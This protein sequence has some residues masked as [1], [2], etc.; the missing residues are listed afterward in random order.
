MKLQNLFSWTGGAA[1]RRER[2]RKLAAAGDRARDRGEWA[3]AARQY[4][5]ALTLDPDRA[6]IWV[7]YGHALKEQG[8]LAGAEAAYKKSI[9]IDEATADAHLQLGHVLKLQGRKTDAIS[10]YLDALIRDPEFSEP[11]RELAALDYPLTDFQAVLADLADAA[12]PNLVQLGLRADSAERQ[13]AVLLNRSEARARAQFPDFCVVDVSLASAVGWAFLPFDF[14]H[15]VLVNVYRGNR[16]LA[17]TVANLRRPAAI[18]AGPK[19]NWF[20][21]DW[22][23]WRYQPTLTELTEL[24]FQRGEDSAIAPNP[25][26][27]QGAP[28]DDLDFEYLLRA[29]FLDE[30]GECRTRCTTRQLSARGLIQLYYFDYLGRLPDPDGLNV[31]LR[32]MTRGRLTVDRFRS[33]V[34]SSEEFRRREIVASDRLGHMACIPYVRLYDRF[35]FDLA[36]PV[37]SCATLPADILADADDTEFL[38]RCYAEILNR[39]PTGRELDGLQEELTAGKVTRLDL[40]RQFILEAADRGKLLDIDLSQSHGLRID[41]PARD[42]YDRPI[43]EQ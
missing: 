15:S 42:G 40:L 14:H 28:P 27:T 2:A 26:A 22:K 34:L 11:R 32:R 18:A 17:A 35:R 1:A 43:V 24:V 30:A 16:L 4:E 13:V 6:P 9:E 31:W 7:Q 33:L 21:I 37:Q 3:I 20:Q 5:R 12:P 29:E 39:D 41:G 8:D 25:R 23:D 38:R 36:P 10:A 19:Y